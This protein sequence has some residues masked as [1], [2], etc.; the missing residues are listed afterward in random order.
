MKKARSMIRAHRHTSLRH[1]RW[2]SRH[3]ITKTHT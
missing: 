3:D 1:A 2:T